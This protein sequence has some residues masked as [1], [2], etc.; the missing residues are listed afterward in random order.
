MNDKDEGFVEAITTFREGK[1]CNCLTFTV[2]VAEMKESHRTTWWVCIDR[3]D[4]K[5]DAKPWDSGRYTPYHTEIKERATH[6]AK[7]WA[8][9][10]DAEYLGDI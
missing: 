9:F 1:T 5:K 6:T 3:S 8:K 10:L 4:R 2:G 7:D